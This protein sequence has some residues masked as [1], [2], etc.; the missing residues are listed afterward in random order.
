MK[1]R[2]NEVNAKFWKRVL[3]YIID[4]IIVNIIIVWPFEGTI[5]KISEGFNTGNFISVYKYLNANPDFVRNMLPELG[6]IF[7]VIAVLTIAYWTILEYKT[8]QTIGKMIMNI[9]VKSERK[10][11]TIGQCVARSISKISGIL[12]LIDCIGLIG[13]GGQRFLE[14]ASGTRVIE[15]RFML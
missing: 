6:I 14:K 2:M 10:E 3:A 7:I 13:G 15:K 11:L 4:A 5:K 1:L 9:Q 12:L 8:K